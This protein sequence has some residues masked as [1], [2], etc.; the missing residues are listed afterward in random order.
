MRDELSAHRDSSLAQHLEHR[1]PWAPQKVRKPRGGTT[2]KK[3]NQI[4]V[5]PQRNT[6]Q[7]K[8]VK[9]KRFLED[10]P[11]RANPGVRC[12]GVLFFIKKL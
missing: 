7:R 1:P 5:N 9:P 10:P 6:A 2:E 4:A 3:K 8:E 11:Q 12:A